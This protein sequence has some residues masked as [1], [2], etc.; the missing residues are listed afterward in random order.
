MMSQSRRVAAAFLVVGSLVLTACGLKNDAVDSLGTTNGSGALPAGSGA[1]ATTGG[2][3]LGST[4]TSALGTS[5]GGTTG[6]FTGSTGTSGSFSGTGASGTGTTGSTSGTTSTGGTTGT[7]SGGASNGPC[8]VPT[9]GDTTGITSSTINI[10]LHAPLTGTGTPFPNTSFKAGSQTFW[11]QPGHK[12]CGRKVVV[13]FRDDTYKPSGARAVCSDFARQDFLGIGGGGTDQIQACATTPLVQSTGMP[14]LSAGVTTNGLTS[15]NNYFALSLTYEQQGS[16]VVRNAKTQGI[17]KPAASRVTADHGGKKAQWAIVTGNSPNFDGATSGI[18]KALD[19][20]HIPYRTYRVDQNGDYQAAATQFGSTLALNGF[21][22]MYVDA[23]PGYFVFMTGGYYG[24]GGGA[25]WVGPGVTY[26]EVTVA[27]Y[28]C[29]STKNAISGHAWF[30]APAPGIDRATNEFKQAYNSS[31]D[32]IEWTLWGL[33]TAIWQLLKQASDNLTR[34]NFIASSTQAKIPG[35]VYPPLD[36]AQQGGHF[37]GTGAWVQKV[38]CS[39]T[40][41]NQNQPGSWLTVGSNYLAL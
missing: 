32:D 37:G 35:S 29:T 12:V 28:I 2:S 17:A 13:N 21:K 34:Q 10:G 25:N 41:P 4:G 5:A 40:E 26:T 15:L 8:G 6:G 14:Y 19:A 33:S 18:Q 30:L 22:T 38:T 23:A 3:G 11:E 7:T 36:F 1:G 31:Y 27:Q 39:Q 20:A 24:S 9:G 16:L